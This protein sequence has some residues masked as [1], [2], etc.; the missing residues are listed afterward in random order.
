MNPGSVDQVPTTSLDPEATT[1]T[2]PPP[3]RNPARKRDPP[4]Y[5]KDYA[6]ALVSFLEEGKEE[7]RAT[8]GP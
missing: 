6:R 7:E 1:S 4:A 5:L 3:R 8:S 2:L